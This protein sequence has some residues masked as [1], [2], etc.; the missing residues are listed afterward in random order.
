MVF[1][2]RDS[3]PELPVALGVLQNRL[4]IR[5]ALKLERSAYYSSCAVIALSPGMKESV[6]RTGYPANQVHIIPNACDAAFTVDKRSS[7]RAWLNDNP[8]V[9]DRKLVVYLG[10]VGRIHGVSYLASLADSVAKLADDICFAVI[11]EGPEIDIVERYAR[12]LGVLNRN[13]YLIPEMPKMD[14]PKVL[15][16][17]AAGISTVI[18]VPELEA[19]SAN[20]FFDY[21]AASLPVIIN[22]GGWQRQVL[23]QSGAGVR[24]PAEDFAEAAR[25]LTNYLHDEATLAQAGRAAAELAQT[26]FSRDRL[27]DDLISLL[28]KTVDQA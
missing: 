19:N 12:K 1:E 20:K 26:T 2:V 18:P 5:L 17:A 27:A 21:L 8:W 14:T 9:N 6:C 24:L 3:W 13:F 4:L 22:Y 7:A 10:T 15:A 25:I 16:A 28:E 11:G 23:E